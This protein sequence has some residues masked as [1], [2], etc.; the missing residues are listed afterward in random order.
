MNRLHRA[1]ASLL[2]AF[3]TVLASHTAYAGPLQQ[4]TD[5]QTNSQT[6][7]HPVP[8][9]P[10]TDAAPAQNDAPF[11]GNTFTRIMQPAIDALRA[12]SPKEP[13]QTAKPQA[14]AK[15]NAATL[16]VNYP[17]FGN[18]PTVAAVPPGETYAAFIGLT[19]DV[20]QDG[21][22]DLV[23]IEVDGR[24]NVLLNPGTGKFSDFK[25][26]SSN[27]GAVTIGSS[28]I[29]AIT[30][31]FNND[32]YPDI[33]E[34]DEVSNGAL[35]FINQKNGTFANPVVVAMPN[36]V[37][38]TFT[39]HGGSLLALDTNG[40]K[41]P[42]L[43]AINYSTYAYDNSG[44][45]Y[46]G[47]SIVTALGKGDGTF[48]APK[49]QV[50]NMYGINSIQQRYNEVAVGDLNHDG[51]PDLILPIGVFPPPTYQ[52]QVIALTAL[53]KGDGTFTGLPTSLPQTQTFLGSGSYTQGSSMIADI[54]GDG[55]PDFI[56]NGGFPFV[57]V[58]YGNGDGTLKNAVQVAQVGSYYSGAGPAVDYAD[59]NGDGILDIISRNTGYVAVYLGKGKGVFSQTPLVSLVSG[60]TAF[61]EPLPADFNGDGIADIVS[62][63]LYM[64]N[65]AFYAGSNGTFA[66]PKALGSDNNQMASSFQVLATADFNGDGSPDIVADSPST[67]TSVSL[68]PNVVLGIN[69]GKG[70]FT[71]TTAYTATVLSAASVYGMEPIVADLNGDGKLDL[72][73]YGYSGTLL[74]GLNN[75]DNTF[76]KLVTLPTPSALACRFNNIDIGDVNGDGLPDIVA[77]YPGDTACYPYKGSHP[78]GVYTFLNH[79]GGKFTNAFTP[80]GFSA[81]AI[82]LA[83]LNGDGKLDIAVSDVYSKSNFYYLYDLPGNGDGT[84]DTSRS[85]LLLQNTLVQSILAG[86]FDGDGKQDLAV[87]VVTQVDSNAYVVYDTTGTYIMKGNGDLTFQLPTQYLSGT[88]AYSGQVVDLN[89][90]GRPD[91][92]LA[93]G[94]IGYY[95][96]VTDGNTAALINLGAG[97][98]ASDTTF[99]SAPG[100]AAPA[101]FVGDFNGD[102]AIDILNAPSVSVYTSTSTL[103]ELFLNQGGI[104]MT[105]NASPTTAAQGVPVTFTVALTPSVS[106]QS[107]TGTVN[108]FSGSTLLQSVPVANGQAA[109]TLSTLP[110]GTDAIKAVYSGDPNFN[111]ASATTSVAITALSPNFALSVTTPSALTVAQGT[112]GTV[113]FTVTA[114]ATFNGTVSF[115]CGLATVQA[116]CTVSPAS[117]ALAPGQSAI[118]TAVVATTIAN[119]TRQARNETPFLGKG[120]AGV[121]MAGLVLFGFP[122]RKRFVSLLAMM[123]LGVIV[124]A[125]LS[126][127]GDSLYSGT[128]VGTTSVNIIGSSGSVT[129][130]S[131][132]MLTVTP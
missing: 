61:R 11:S 93:I 120:L 78:S 128:P 66:G 80:V 77:T 124:S 89:G 70:Q 29:F 75:G 83:D 9:Q 43:V 17:G 110:I 13:T 45:P 114:N 132:F 37:G 67:N 105:L 125:G 97:Q 19:L 86:D 96:D 4:V 1:T 41:I 12:R 56:F 121:A 53:G 36:S 30:A 28:V 111:A 27:A 72:L 107:P 42:D 82:K 98:F 112:T 47:I 95:V 3:G 115:T 10:A 57:G 117:Y 127:C 131:S 51:K 123:L 74:V 116:T 64:N 76:A 26:T 100:T 32:G 7:I 54:D 119:N 130:S 23:S 102:G 63:D 31:D 58:Y 8:G 22:P 38:N 18:V 81:Y 59:V 6:S 87:G 79:P 5:P 71:Y 109:L 104:A 25:I 84:F 24:L 50:T 35:V 60:G 103:S 40:D 48:A 101:V 69:N 126:G 92:A 73:F 118:I 129:Q 108:F 15:P 16:P 113:T 55:N 122:R 34:L 2:L 68:N 44:N 20:N 52:G 65:F 99:A 91:L 33:A 46:T 21:K 49:E 39:S 88:Y 90:D 14:T 62:L 85:Q 106:S 94:T